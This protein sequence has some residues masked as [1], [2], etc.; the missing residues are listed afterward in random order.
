MSEAEDATSAIE[1]TLALADAWSCSIQQINDRLRQESEE[2]LRLTYRGLSE[3]L[4]LL[5]GGESDVGSLTLAM[6]LLSVEAEL[7][8][9]E[10]AKTCEKCR[11][12]MYGQPC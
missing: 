10:H 6:S 4:K 7:D 5:S 8:N 12:G 2:S 3:T 9:R 1:L 11:V